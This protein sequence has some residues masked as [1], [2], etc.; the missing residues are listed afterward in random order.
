MRH[1]VMAE[2][3]SLRQAWRPA[4]CAVAPAL[5]ALALSGCELVPAP[6]VQA[7]PAVQVPQSQAPSP[8]ETAQPRPQPDRTRQEPALPNDEIRGR[9]A[10]LVPLS[11][12]NAAVGQSIANAANLA[13]L[14]SG[15]QRIRLT[16][17]D[18]AR[19]GA[20]AAANEALAQGNRLF[21]GPLLADD[22]R[23]AAGLAR[24]AGVPVVAFSNDVSVAGDG[25]YLMG[26]SP[27]Q[28]VA[29][30]IGYARSQGLTR[31]AGLVPEGIY[32][33]R[34]SQAL[35]EASRRGAA[36]IV[37][38]ETLGHDAAGVRAAVAGVA[39][40]GS[41]DAVL[42]AD[43]PR[44]AALAVAF[45]RS[46]V[47]P[48]ARILGT[49]LWANDPAIGGNAA[50]R[51]AWFAAV[52]DVMFNQMRAR[53]RARYGPNPYRLASLGYDA[54]LLAERSARDWQPGRPFPE[55]ALHDPAGFLGI[56]GPFRFAPGNVAE[57]AL[58][59]REVTAGGTSVVSP[60]P[61]SLD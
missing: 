52:S 6:A 53:Y 20:A 50:L 10:V 47:S 33:R 60:A 24:R 49:E 21:L 23:A 17:Y 51:G 45:V 44:L 19:A 38:I 9:V 12:P 26:F 2:E 3:R 46:G 22:V 57:R 43:T 13:L 31:F 34:V 8:V 25:V 40:Q 42:I 4:G 36:L 55:R 54:V 14:D 28:S 1:R 29:R 16:V 7:P 15:G 27:A 39:A 32:G 48:R 37:G 58:E 11:G 61:R 35:I 59:V 5:A 41:Y 18:T 56:D 30:V